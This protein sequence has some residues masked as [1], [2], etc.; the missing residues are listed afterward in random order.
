MSETGKI[1]KN[2]Q[3]RLLKA[4]KKADEKAQKEVNNPIQ[5]NNTKVK[6]DEI[7]P[8]QY[9][10]LRKTAIA[11]LKQGPIKPYPHK[12]HV[13]ISLEEF[14]SKYSHLQPGEH[15]EDTLVH[16]AGRLH[17]KRESG[18][19]LIFYDVRAENERLQI[20]ANVSLYKS[21]EEFYKINEILKRGDIVGCTGFPGKSKLGELSIFA[22]ELVLLAPCLYQLPHLH[23]GLKDKETRFRQRYLDLIINQDVR[24][25]F[26]VRARI[27]NYVRQFLDGIGF[28][29]VETPMM[30]MI[31][32]G[33]IAKPFITHHN[34]LNMDLFMRIAPELYL[35]ML[36][37]GGFPRVYEIGRQFRNEG[38]DLTHNPEFSTCEFYMAYADYNDLMT[39][40]EDMISGMVK[41]ICGTYKVTYKPE[42]VDENGKETEPI[43]VDF[44]PPFRRIDIM[45]ELEKALHCTMPDPNKL[46]SPES[47]KLLDQLCVKHNVDCPPPRTASRMLDKLI[48]D[49]LEVQCIS[50][51]FIMNHPS[52]MSPLA[53]GH[54]DIVGLTE[55]F[56][57]FVLQKEICNSYT[58]L[59]D[60]VVQRER[61][62]EQAKA[63]AAGD[64]EAMYLDENFL[65]ALGYGLPPTAG[66]GLGL[67]R[68]TMFLTNTN[69]IK[70]VIL[71]PAMRPDVQ[72]PSE[73]A[74]QAPVPIDK[75]EVKSEQAASAPSMP[76][77]SGS[78][79]SAKKKNKKK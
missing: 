26:V 58:E 39:I 28:I 63:K 40:T 14:I 76:P 4:Q 52:V 72:K 5:S 49:F 51:T 74:S 6:D 79:G 11:N 77:V 10:E 34:E 33:A 8:S 67:D 3:K 61:F 59:N 48:G 12:F 36:V 18:S 73:E 30:N 45:S 66:W 60:P 19:K 29:E 54:R 64:D 35:K 16:I 22:K 9:Y 55:R 17:A 69:N 68:L 43:I 50:P 56:E 20:M 23:F 7:D 75:G 31:P 57:L 25:R 21:E 42:G 13:S 44:T 70:E 37:V 1:S 2:E 78:E 32:G 65:T 46:N 53:K 27:I 38:I 41:S 71:F 15:L 47:V 24:Q 62:E